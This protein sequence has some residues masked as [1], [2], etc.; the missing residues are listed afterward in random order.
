MISLITSSTT[1]AWYFPY[2]NQNYIASYY[3]YGMHIYVG[4]LTQ[5]IYDK[6]KFRLVNEC[7]PAK[8]GT[9]L[10]SVYFVAVFFEL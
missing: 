8:T 6:R 9:R 4:K 7:N 3:I 5:S 2:I 1:D 10:S